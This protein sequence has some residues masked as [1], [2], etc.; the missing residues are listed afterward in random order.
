MP[1][2]SDRRSVAIPSAEEAAVA[3]EYR[4]TV[5][6]SIHDELRWLAVQS[7]QYSRRQ[8]D[9][10]S[11]LHE[12]INRARQFIGDPPVRWP[13][14]PA[15]IESVDRVD[16]VAAALV[17]N[18]YRDVTR[19]RYEKLS[20][21]TT[22]IA[23]GANASPTR[24]RQPRR[25]QSA[26]FPPSAVSRRQTSTSALKSRSRAASASSR[27][28]I[29]VCPICEEERA[30]MDTLVRVASDAASRHY[31]PLSNEAADVAAAALGRSGLRRHHPFEM[32]DGPCPECGCPLASSRIHRPRTVTDDASR[33]ARESRR[34]SPLRGGRPPPASTA[35]AVISTT[36]RGTSPLEMRAA[37]VNEAMQAEALLT[38][39]EAVSA[40]MSFS[41]AK[42]P[43]AVDAA[44]VEEHVSL[45]R[46]DAHI[47]D[48]RKAMD[49]VG[50]RTGT[51]TVGL[52][53]PARCSVR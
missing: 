20:Q 32:D 26:D 39:D 29:V 48:L 24:R 10:N 47:A 1:L 49:T 41:Q 19:R 46:I 5:R 33:G 34:V 30:A 18:A 6:R 9:L 12:E 43:P 28:R 4:E 51:S 31:R 38:A 27:G 13:A 42:P 2:C 14:S 35:K 15:V 8:S 16:A 22:T 11:L 50:R 25:S 37:V 17:D 52:R 7:M 3:S 21:P 44:A 45:E 40:H 36:N 23:S 53:R